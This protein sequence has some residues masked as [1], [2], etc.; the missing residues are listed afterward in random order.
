MSFEPYARDMS[1]SPRRLSVA[2]YNID[3]ARHFDPPARGNGGSRRGAVLEDLLVLEVLH[4]A[5]V[6]ALQEAIVGP[7]A[8]GAG[9]RDTVAEIGAVL[10][11]D[12]HAFHGSRDGSA[13]E[14]GVALLC[15]HPAR[16][17]GLDLPRAFWSPWRR[18]VVL[19]EIGAWIV[20]SL[21]LEVWPLVGA[22]S[23][24]AQT[25]ALLDLVEEVDRGGGRP[26]VLAGDFN[27]EPGSAPHRL[28]LRRG[29][30]PTLAGRQ[31]TWRFPGLP[32]HLD[33][34]YARG[35]RTVQAG[36]ERRARGSDHFPVWADL[37]I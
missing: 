21:H 31:A 11:V 3:K 18:S 10:G 5:D 22:A 20:A 27:C 15:R 13:R 16:F 9:A 8:A 26:V 1:D 33:H 35:A 34:I 29:F 30:A 32:L 7:L 17:R 2:S 24:L 28:L 23:R 12:G 25:R 37:E 14:W 4:Q 6:L 19:G 36:V